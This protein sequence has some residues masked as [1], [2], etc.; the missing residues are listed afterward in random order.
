[1]SNSMS[2]FHMA[3]GDGLFLSGTS[4]MAM[5]AVVL[6]SILVA[7]AVGGSEFKDSFYGDAALVLAGAGFIAGAVLDCFA[8]KR[9]HGN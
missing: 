7:W 9:K 8:Q 1:M 4:L 5:C 6:F 3:K 2:D